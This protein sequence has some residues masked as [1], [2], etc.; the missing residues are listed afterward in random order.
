MTDKI[1]D[2]LLKASRYE[3]RK[4]AADYI[5]KLEADKN[6]ALQSAKAE[7]RRAERAEQ[8]RDELA[9]ALI[10]IKGE[11]AKTSGLSELENYCAYVAESALAKLGADASDKSNKAG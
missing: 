7:R 10:S 2:R 9:A 8:Q 1:Q 6:E 4:E 11:I 5:A 3:V